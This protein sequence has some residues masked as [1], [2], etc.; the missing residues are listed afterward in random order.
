MRGMYY[1]IAQLNI[2]PV[3][4]VT[5]S[6]LGTPSL[7]PDGGPSGLRYPL[8]SSEWLDENYLHGW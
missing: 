5:V 3:P 7:A 1:S 4:L 2:S 8:Q 6:L